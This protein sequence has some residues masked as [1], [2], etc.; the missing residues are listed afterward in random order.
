MAKFKRMVRVASAFSVAIGV[1]LALASPAAAS[2]DPTTSCGNMTS[3]G[4]CMV[5]YYNSEMKGSSVS[6]SGGQR[7]DFAGDKFLTSGA[8][9][10][11]AVKNNAASAKFLTTVGYWGTIYYNSYGV[12]P[13]DAFAPN[14]S[15]SRLKN[16]Y[17]EN[18]SYYP[19][20]VKPSGCYA[21]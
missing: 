9:K 8:G 5:L 1:G 19:G 4:H 13:C 14:H 16:T 18:A 21:F 11:S 17:N 3:N 12:G 15:T 2:A 10:G 20:S 7:S 6:Y